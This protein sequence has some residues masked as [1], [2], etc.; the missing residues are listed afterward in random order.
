MAA[1]TAK[2][3]S[4]M[5]QL[6]DSVLIH[7]S[8]LPGAGLRPVLFSRSLRR[9]SPKVTIAQANASGRTKAEKAHRTRTSSESMACDAL[10]VAMT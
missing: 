5:T 9:R 7:D 1:G 10:V 2:A 4:A 3:A 6:H 8:L